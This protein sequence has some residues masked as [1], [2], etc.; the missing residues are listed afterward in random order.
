MRSSLL[1]ALSLSLLATTA[2]AAKGPR[3]RGQEN[4]RLGRA[5]VAAVDAMRADG[6]THKEL[7]VATGTRQIRNWAGRMVTVPD[8]EMA[9]L[10]VGKQQVTLTLGGQRHH[11]IAPIGGSQK[12]RERSIGR[13]VRQVAP[14]L[15]AG[16][17]RDLVPGFRAAA[18]AR[19]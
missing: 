18:K 17:M 5:T 4:L 19:H 1:V 11:I 3:P 12:D 10:A 9:T 16:A 2:T 13:Q 7:Y 15:T 8:G 6:V 14:G